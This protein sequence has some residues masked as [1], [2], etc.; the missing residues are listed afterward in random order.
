MDS[1]KRA[2]RC[3]AESL[4]G[5]GGALAD[6]ATAPTTAATKPEPMHRTS[7]RSLG[8]LDRCPVG[9]HLGHALRELRGVV[10]KRDDGVR[11]MLLGMA[12]H[13]LVSFLAGIF[14]DFRVRFDVA[15][16]DRLEAAEQALSDRRGSDHDSPDDAD[17]ADDRSTRDVVACGHNHRCSPPRSEEHTSEL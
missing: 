13:S 16:D 1:K 11:A 12:D 14:A 15:A 17:V 3:S 10:A 5:G 9:Q 8:E 2:A 7:A 6:S 4:A